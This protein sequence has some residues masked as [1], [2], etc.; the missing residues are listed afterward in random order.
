M[1]N[2]RQNDWGCYLKHNVH[3]CA[4]KFHM[5]IVGETNW[6]KTALLSKIDLSDF[7]LYGGLPKTFAL[8]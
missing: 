7:F 6:W 8:N 1:V 4:S 2:V 5:E 3:E